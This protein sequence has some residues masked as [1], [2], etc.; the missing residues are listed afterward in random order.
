[1]RI[2]EKVVA[3]VVQE[4]SKKMNDPNYSAVL[5]GSFVQDQP[6][7]CEYIKSSMDDM[8]GA[9]AVVTGADGSGVVLRQATKVS[10]AV[11]PRARTAPCCVRYRLSY[12]RVL[13]SRSSSAVKWSFAIGSSNSS[14]I[15][16][17]AS[18][19]S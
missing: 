10:V 6:D 19:L 18:T 8:G 17:W 7:T 13:R 4:A 2:P 5:V 3:E 12:A 15:F 14:P 1:M 16:V 11:E 9:E